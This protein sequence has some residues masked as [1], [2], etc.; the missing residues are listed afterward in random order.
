[1]REKSMLDVYQ[2]DARG[3]MVLGNDLMFKES[4]GRRPLSDVFREQARVVVRAPVRYD[5]FGAIGLGVQM[6]S[7][8][9][10]VVHAGCSVARKQLSL[11]SINKNRVQDEE[12]LMCKALL[13]I[14]SEVR[15]Q[16]KPLGEFSARPDYKRVGGDKKDE[17]PSPERWASR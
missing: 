9:R 10:I 17:K 11:W 1:M 2:Y 13:L 16:K 12:A 3:P 4:S 14:I 8:N 5:E 7:E 6:F 15:R